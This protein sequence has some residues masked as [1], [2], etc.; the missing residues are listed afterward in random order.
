[1]HYFLDDLS[2]EHRTTLT[3]LAREVS[4]P[5]GVRIFE[6]H[7]RADRFWVLRRGGVD[8]D[9]HIPGHRPSVIETVH[10]GDLLGWS[11]LFPP[12]L[13]T[14]GARTRTPVEALEFDAAEVRARCEADPAFGQQLVLRCAAVI[15]RRLRTT[16]TRLLELYVPYGTEAN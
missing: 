7:R 9:L 5:A 13:W 8:L 4:F 11:W 10:G 1:M 3:D 14:L 15:G 16:R 2:Q 12:Y 6:E